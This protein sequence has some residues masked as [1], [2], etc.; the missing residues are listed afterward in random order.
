MRAWI[1]MAGYVLATQYWLV[2]SAGP[3]VAVLAA[4]LGALWLPWGWAA[5]GC[6]LGS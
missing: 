5:H 6:S 1:G 2:G 3:L 4:G